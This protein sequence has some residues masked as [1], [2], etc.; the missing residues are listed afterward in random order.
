MSQSCRAAGRAFPGSAAVTPCTQYA[1]KRHFAL[2][3]FSSYSEASPYRAL[4]YVRHLF[5]D[6]LQ[7]SFRMNHQ[8]RDFGIVGFSAQG[9][10]FPPDFLAE[11]FERSADSVFGI[12]N[13]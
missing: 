4:F 5:S 8:L 10:Q 1:A 13:R 3:F 6:L 2:R 9:V 7:F 11:K 12:S